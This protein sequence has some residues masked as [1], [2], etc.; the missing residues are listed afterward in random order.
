MLDVHIIVSHN[1]PPHWQNQCRGSVR[2]AAGMAGFT[3]VLH[4]VQGIIGHIGKARAAGY[5]LG[6]QPYATCVDDDDYV[7]P[8][9]FLQMAQALRSGASAVCTPEYALQNGHFGNGRARHH[10]IAYRR[11]ILID[12]TQWPCCG[13]VAQMQRIGPDAVDLPERAYVHRLYS[14]SKA[15]VMRRANP[16]ELERA[17]GY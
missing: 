4:E 12:H 17:R 15:R 9:A 11:D 10:L 13:D 7:L 1:T 2:I 8:H 14:T 6:T 3:V 16:E 5:A